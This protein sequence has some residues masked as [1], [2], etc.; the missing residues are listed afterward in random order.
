MT[1]NWRRSNCCLLGMDAAVNVNQKY[2]NQTNDSSFFSSSSPFFLSHLR[3]YRQLRS[4]NVIYFGDG[5]KTKRNRKCALRSCAGGIFCVHAFEMRPSQPY[6]EHLGPFHSTMR[7][8]HS[9]LGPFFAFFSI[10]AAVV[11]SLAFNSGCVYEFMAFQRRS[12]GDRV[13]LGAPYVSCVLSAHHLQ[14][15][16]DKLTRTRNKMHQN[17]GYCCCVDKNDTP[18]EF[19]MQIALVSALC[20]ID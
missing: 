8:S 15:V 3:C 16:D 10:V 1:I 20:S 13:L 11:N 14:S 17:N 4:T 2:T 12:F 18:N 19:R 7:K 6:G 9:L 5:K